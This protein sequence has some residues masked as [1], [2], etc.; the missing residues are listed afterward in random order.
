MVR[1]EIIACKCSLSELQKAPLQCHKGEWLL[2]ILKFLSVWSMQW[3]GSV[4]HLSVVTDY[5]SSHSISLKMHSLSHHPHPWSLL[6]L[7][8]RA[9]AVISFGDF[10][11]CQSVL[12]SSHL[13]HP[14]YS[15]WHP[16][17]SRD[18]TLTDDSK[19]RRSQTGLT[20]GLLIRSE[21]LA[22]GNTKPLQQSGTILQKTHTLAA[23]CHSFTLYDVHIRTKQM[24]IHFFF[25]KAKG[26]RI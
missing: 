13:P 17:S 5:C 6:R 16:E 18:A 24:I 25:G 2:S 26:W 3:W 22:R 23:L 8:C 7:L 1:R 19:Q 10:V 14:L 11:N 20:V 12:F 15:V 21:K 9:W 4:P